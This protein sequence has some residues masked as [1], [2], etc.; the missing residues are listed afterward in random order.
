MTSP[1]RN[2]NSP[3]SDG[4]KS[5]R[6]RTLDT[7]AAVVPEVKAWEGCDC[8]CVDA[9]CPGS[10]AADELWPDGPTVGL[11]CIE[12]F[13][14]ICN[15]SS[16]FCRSISVICRFVGARGGCRFGSKHAQH[17]AL[18]TRPYLELTLRLQ[19]HVCT[20]HYPQLTI[21]REHLRPFVHSLQDLRFDLL[22]RSLLPHP[23]VQA[24]VGTTQAH[25]ISRKP[26]QRICEAPARQLPIQS[27][28]AVLTQ[29][30]RQLECIQLHIRVAV[31][32]SLDHGGNDIL[33][34]SLVIAVRLV[35]HIE[36]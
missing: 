5:N 18:H 2:C 33:R 21:T 8:D 22:V 3:G 26:Q 7:V 14:A 1:F 27:N 9:A 11:S 13:S 32:K 10:S 31:R 24:A 35:A 23:L 17:S 30:I 12:S 19:F 34:S 28:A 6:A 16:S 4:W 36:N 20:L 25:P 29:R 15:S